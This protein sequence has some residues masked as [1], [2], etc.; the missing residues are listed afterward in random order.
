MTRV[1]ASITSGDDRVTIEYFEQDET[2]RIR[3]EPQ[4]DGHDP[5]IEEMEA[6]LRVLEE[7]M[8]DAGGLS[9]LL[10]G[11]GATRKASQLKRLLE[12]GEDDA[13]PDL[14]ALDAPKIEIVEGELTFAQRQH[15]SKLNNYMQRACREMQRGRLDATH[16]ANVWKAYSG[17]R[18]GLLA[19]R[20]S[21]PSEDVWQFLWR[22]LS[23]EGKINPSRMTHVYVLARD[24]GTAGCALSQAQRL[25]VMEA[26]FIEGYKKQAI[27]NW[28]RAAATIGSDPEVAQSYWELGVRMCSLEGDLERAERAANT[29]LDPPYDVDPRIL[30]PFL[31][32]CT[33]NEA[34]QEKAWGV[35]RRLRSLLGDSMTIEDYDGIINCFLSTNQ[36]QYGLE[37]FVDMMF[38]GAIDLHGQTKLPSAV[39]NRFFLGKWLKRLIGAG[40]LDG[41]MNVLQFMHSKGIMGAAI[42]VNGLI[43]A[44]MRTETAENQQKAE[45]LAWAMIDS[46]LLYVDLRER[47]ALMEWPAQLYSNSRSQSR[48]DGRQAVSFVPRATLETISLLAENYRQRGLHG[49]MEELWAASKDAKISADVFMMNQFMESY[50]NEGK[51]DKA[52]DLYRRLTREH[53]IVPDSHTFLDLFKSLDVHFIRSTSLSQEDRAEAEELC[54]SMF[55]DMMKAGRSILDEEGIHAAL[56]RTILLSFRRCEDH[57][58]LLVALRALRDHFGFVPS[59]MLVL[60]MVAGRPAQHRDSPRATRQLVKSS[61]LIERML[62]EG[63][64]E[65]AESG[66]LRA[67]RTPEE[68]ARELVSVLEK[69]V[70]STLEE[71]SVGGPRMSDDEFQA[72]Y[73]TAAFEMGVEPGPGD[74]KRWL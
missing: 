53:R 44:L 54:R 74:A 20:A 35:Y 73:G 21:I 10:K 37:A 49:R 66:E 48:G 17:A 12:T 39:S 27:D 34:T 33:V 47:K 50:N 1:P 42:Q 45:E 23:W 61:H 26:M 55:R 67:P 14:A 25:L 8:R 16:I 22:V 30:L 71:S 9:Q 28:K 72:R 70:L 13:E 41:A 24:M 51:G 36:T 65:A 4:D 31:R 11:P 7:R 18:R 62:T 59:D 43:G 58:G 46:R 29:L 5:E 38:S 64:L 3:P 6:Q 40:D 69:H 2:G 57:F 32:A 19:S 68:K 56:A 60:E 15:V 52:R 63:R